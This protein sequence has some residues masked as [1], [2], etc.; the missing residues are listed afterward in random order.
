M[1]MYDLSAFGLH[2]GRAKRAMMQISDNLDV[3]L[4]VARLGTDLVARLDALRETDPIFWSEANQAW[5]VTGHKEVLDG[6]YG[7]LP[8]SSVRL[9]HFAVAHLDPAAVEREL[10]NFLRIPHTW[11]INMDGAQHHRVRRLVQ[12]A[13]GKP[14]VEALR[15][16]IRRYVAEALDSVAQADGPIDFVE[17]VARVIPARMVLKVFGLDDTLIARMQRWSLCMNLSGNPGLP[18]EQLREVEQVICELEEV[19]RPLIADR[20]ANPTGDFLSALVTAEDGGDRLSDYEV[21]GMCN[22]TLIA[23]HDTTVN[24]MVLGVAAL[25][26]DAAALAALRAEPEFSV[27]KVMEIQRMAQ[28]STLMSRVATEDFTWNGHAIRQG[29]FVLLCQGAANRDPAVFPEPDR[30]DFT[31]SQQQNLVFA[32]GLHHCIGH[33]LAK[34]VLGEFFPAFINRFDFE[35]VD[36]QLDFAE[37]LAFRG[38]NAMPVRLRERTA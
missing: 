5:I 32:P 35:L 37:S 10:P 18:L 34:M 9:P 27:D 4:D 33:L 30:F 22:I 13:F 6:Y 15:P 14:V 26:R 1:Q 19:F 25:A 21:Y 7:R 11:P 29:Q 8:L 12:K 16:D 38:L 17:Q 23:G 2:G 28:M 20:R 31:R 3:V 36:D 24:T